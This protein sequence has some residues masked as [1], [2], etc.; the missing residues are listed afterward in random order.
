M[1][2]I[3]SIGT[4][5]KRGSLTVAVT[6]ATGFVGRHLCKHLADQGHAVRALVRSSGRT[7]ALPQSVQAVP[8]DV[9]DRGALN[10]L[11]DKADAVIHLIGIIAERPGEGITFERLHVE[12]TRQVV[13]AAQAAGV[14]RFVH[15]SALGSRFDAKANYHRTK[16][17]AESIVRG[18]RLAWTIIRPSLIHGPN[19][20]FTK[21]AAAWVRGQAP[22][23]LFMPY[24]GSG[25]VGTGYKYHLQ[26]VF[27]GDVAE[28]FAQAMQRDRAIK[29]VYSLG[30]Q[31]QV[32]WPELLTTFR[33]MM[34]H[35]PKWRRP[36]PIPAWYAGGLSRAF[37]FLGM[38][39]LLPFN[40]DQ[41]LMSQEE[42]T[43]EI[44]RVREH[45]GVHPRGFRE[46]LAEYVA[47]L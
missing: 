34:V 25:P 28:T 13:E 47:T 31:D 10:R 22:P 17:A 24:F 5:G 46:S 27:V 11:C 35:A 40:T 12:A 2:D 9:F 38:Q 21:M 3:G 36:I 6:G 41:V 39:T 33:D 23:F 15:M 29:E 30:G 26:P 42:S 16:F 43:C 19:G 14:L 18:S 1:A 8:G 44:A 37:A 7:G 32:T 20:E 45:L 4:G